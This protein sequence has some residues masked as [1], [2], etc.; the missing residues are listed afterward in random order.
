VGVKIYFETVASGM[1]AKLDPRYRIIKSHSHGP[2]K[3]PGNGSG[4]SV[5]KCLLDKFGTSMV[6]SNK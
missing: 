1:A 6:S 3:S 5:H 2:S 4:N